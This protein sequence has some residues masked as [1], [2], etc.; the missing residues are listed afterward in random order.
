MHSA[1]MIRSVGKNKDGRACIETGADSGIFTREY[2]KA[3]VTWD[4]AAGHGKIAT[5]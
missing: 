4:C 3:T 1:R 2:S 5:K